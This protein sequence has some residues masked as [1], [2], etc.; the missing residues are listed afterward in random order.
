MKFSIKKE[1]IPFAILGFWLVIL[2]VIAVVL[3]VR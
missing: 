3:L 1:Y 2:L